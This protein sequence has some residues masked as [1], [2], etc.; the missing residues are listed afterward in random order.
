M[1]LSVL[2][3]EEPISM[4]TKQGTASVP[5]EEMTIEPS[6]DPA[7][8]REIRGIWAVPRTVGPW[9]RSWAGTPSERTA[10]KCARLYGVPTLV[11]L[12]RGRETYETAAL[13]LSYV[14]AVFRARGQQITGPR[15]GS[16]ATVTIADVPEQQLLPGQPPERESAQLSV[17]QRSYSRE[18]SVTSKAE[19][20]RP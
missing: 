19:T 10:D 2:S 9:R 7:N 18:L 17:A 20:R 14:G 8:S 12:R 6:V 3:V 16:L 4:A 13:P 5:S 11:A 15:R 1:I